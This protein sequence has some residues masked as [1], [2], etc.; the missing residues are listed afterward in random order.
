MRTTQNQI[1]M[2]TFFLSMLVL[3]FSVNIA[4]C[5]AETVSAAMD[6]QIIIVMTDTEVQISGPSKVRVEVYDIYYNLVAVETNCTPITVYVNL[7]PFPDGVYHVW[8]YT[9]TPDLVQQSVTKG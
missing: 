7:G 1:A 5:S 8:V 6:E 3:G 9:S 2:Y 4:P